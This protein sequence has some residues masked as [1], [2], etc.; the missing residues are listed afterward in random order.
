MKGI[1][2]LLSIALLVAA[3]QLAVY[4]RKRGSLPSVQQ[5]KSFSVL[6]SNQTQYQ[7]LSRS[8]ETG[9]YGMRI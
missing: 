5:A 9:V 6:Q 7:K 1:S 4:L 3:H 8:T 2:M